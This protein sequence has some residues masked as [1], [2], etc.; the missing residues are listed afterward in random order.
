MLHRMPALLAAAA[1]GLW[2]W[3]ADAV[4]QG[5]VG[6]PGEVAGAER[7]APVLDPGDFGTPETARVLAQEVGDG[8]VSFVY[9]Y[10]WK[11][12]MHP[13]RVLDRPYALFRRLV[14]GSVE[15]LEFVRVTADEKSG[16]ILSVEF[17]APETGQVLVGHVYR[18]LE[19]LDIPLY[20][21]RPALR[22]A[23]WNH[24]F[25]PGDSCTAF[26]SVPMIP[27]SQAFCRLS[28]VPL[29]SRPTELFPRSGVSY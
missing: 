7:F 5:C 20:L 21:G 8:K 18:K 26:S 14:Y 17:E 3:R 23:S 1:L 16:K 27:L 29:R 9:Y 10:S 28:A 6:A 15:D 13:L 25:E 12:E 4:V 11:D 19:G 24:L 22:V 2:L